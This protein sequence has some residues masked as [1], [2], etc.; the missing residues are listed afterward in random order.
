[1][2]KRTLYVIGNDVNNLKNTLYIMGSRRATIQA[3]YLWF[4]SD[5]LDYDDEDD[6]NVKPIE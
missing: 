1:M 5:P 2:F 4:R 3:N 6:N